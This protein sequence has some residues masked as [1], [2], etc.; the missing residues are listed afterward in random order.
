M[1][2]TNMINVPFDFLRENVKRYRQL[3]KGQRPDYA[4]FRLWLVTLFLWPMELIIHNWV[5]FGVIFSLFLVAL[6]GMY[7]FWFRNLPNSEPSS[8]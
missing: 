8:L 6:A 3:I 4:P 2:E 7:V 5:A 1:I